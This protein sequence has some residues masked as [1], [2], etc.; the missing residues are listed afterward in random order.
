MPTGRGGC[1][2][3]IKVLFGTVVENRA[4]LIRVSGSE[5]ASAIL[6]RAVYFFAFRVAGSGRTRVHRGAL[7]G[8]FSLFL[9]IHNASRS[10]TGPKHQVATQRPSAYHLHVSLGVLQECLLLPEAK[11]MRSMR[12][13]H[14]WTSSRGARSLLGVGNA[15][16]RT[17]LGLDQFTSR[18]TNGG[19]KRV[20]ARHLCKILRHDPAPVY[21]VTS[22]I[23]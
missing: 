6:T 5:A 2:V 10:Q 22:S 12:A 17:V 20:D 7:G 16:A 8:I 18:K 21:H 23:L 1:H 14:G 13:G 11:A 3:G 19:G 9:L 15:C 4:M